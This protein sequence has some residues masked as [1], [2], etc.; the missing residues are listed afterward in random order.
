MD[1]TYRIS[2]AL[3]VLVRAPVTSTPFSGPLLTPNPVP[4]TD[5]VVCGVITLKS[6]E[7]PTL[8]TLKSTRPVFTVASVRSVSPSCTIC[9]N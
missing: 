1:A 2:M 5:S 9:G 3:I 6:F 7:K 8:S 4:R